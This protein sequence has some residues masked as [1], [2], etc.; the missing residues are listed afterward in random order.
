MTLFIFNGC[1]CTGKDEVSIHGLI[2]AGKSKEGYR[3][4]MICTECG[5]KLHIKWELDD[6][7][8][9]LDCH[10]SVMHW[11]DSDASDFILDIVKGNT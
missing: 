6:T 3:F 9:L 8:N 10:N 11:L 4:T 5:R 7:N 1:K 2:P